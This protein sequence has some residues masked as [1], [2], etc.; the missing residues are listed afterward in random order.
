MVLGGAGSSFRILY[1]MALRLSPLK[2]VVP[3]S[4]SYNTTPSA[5]ISV[6]PLVAWPATCSGAMYLGEPST[7]PSCVRE[8]VEICAMPKSMILT[9]R[10]GM[11]M[12]FAGLMSRC[13]TKFSCA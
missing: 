5:K 6:L 11:I 8:P 4:I 2:G 13:T 3:V 10:F 7:V 12:I 9:L 1:M